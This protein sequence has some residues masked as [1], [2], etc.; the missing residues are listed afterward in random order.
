AA[1]GGV[2]ISD[3]TQ[4]LAHGYFVSEPVAPL[5]LKGFPTR[6]QAYVVRDRRRRARF[7]IA[8]ERGL[9]PFVG[10]ARELSFLTDAA[11]R[12][13]SGRAQVISVVGEAGVGK[14]RLA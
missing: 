4:R 3:A 1:P 6:I 7:Q 11:R 9:T 14:S 12:A 2:L 10:R 5:T 13:A 8:L